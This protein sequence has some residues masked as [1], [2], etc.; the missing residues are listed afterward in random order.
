MN[1]KDLLKHLKGVKKVLEL[2]QSSSDLLQ[3]FTKAESFLNRP[4]HRPEPLTSTD[5]KTLGFDDEWAGKLYT[6]ISN[7]SLKDWAIREQGLPEEVFNMLF[8][9]R[10]GA[11]KVRK[12]W[13]ELNIDSIESLKQAAQENKLLKVPGI[14]KK[15]QNYILEEIKFAEKYRSLWAYYK[16]EQTAHDLFAYLSGCEAIQKISFSGSFRRLSP[17]VAKL[18]FMVA[19]TSLAVLEN[20]LKHL[21]Y[22]T[23]DKPNSSPFAW[24]GYRIS[25]KLPIEFKI[26]SEDQFISTLFIHSADPF[27]LDRYCINGKPLK[28]L[29]Q[30]RTFNSERTIYDQYNLHFTVPEQREPQDNLPKSKQL[31]ESKDLKGILHAHSTYSDG[32]SDLKTLALY[33][34]QLGYQYLGITDHSVSAYYAGGLNVRDIEQQHCEIERLNHELSPFKI[35]KG[36]ESD[37]LTDG[38]LDFPDQILEQFDF[39]IASI[40]SGLDMDMEKATNRL[41]KAICNPYTTIL[42]H[43]TGRL[44]C[45]RRGYPVDH[46][47]VIKACADHQVVLEINANPHRLDLDWTWIPTCLEQGVKLAIN[48]DAHTLEGV[49][50]VKYGL[51]MARKGGA[52]AEHILN[53]LN[54]QELEEYFRNG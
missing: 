35:F 29:I 1:N 49:H 4:G 12:L 53:T 46:R 47:A 42:G 18:E 24:R 33:C 14:G 27:Y 30:D 5:L 54:S 20:L 16:V 2:N 28:T 26:A 39:I 22:L 52:K 44:L 50:N 31:V 7:Q 51:N 37:I 36:I 11:K 15:L 10:L 48:P 8:I 25:D 45:Q 21:D 13:L 38:T 9:R 40:H 6:I 34:K 3:V 19:C 17:I 41:I 23:Y 32:H 43:L